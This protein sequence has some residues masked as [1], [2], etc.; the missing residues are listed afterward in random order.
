MGGKSRCSRKIT[1]SCSRLLAA[2]RVYNFR[3]AYACN[4]RLSAN[5]YFYLGGLLQ[6]NP[7]VELV[8][9]TQQRQ[10]YG[11]TGDKL[12]VIITKTLSLIDCRTP[13]VSLR[14]KYIVFR[15]PLIRQF[16]EFNWSMGLCL[17]KR[18]KAGALKGSQRMHEIP[19]NGFYTS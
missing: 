18:M 9:Q 11:T 1:P 7:R 8:F 19:S 15:Q 4:S 6:W 3:Q 16:N 12:M 13:L 5:L 17:T 14:T 10:V 2:L